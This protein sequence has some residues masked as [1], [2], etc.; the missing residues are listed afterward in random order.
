MLR[1]LLECRLCRRTFTVECNGEDYQAWLDGALAQDVLGYLT[2]DER[3]LLI[4]ETCG[5]C[6]D[7][8]ST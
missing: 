8:L 3:E 7:N 1:L 2:A 5:E 4:S 6:F